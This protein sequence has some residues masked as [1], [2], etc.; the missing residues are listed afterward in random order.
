MTYSQLRSTYKDDLISRY[1]DLGF[2]EM[3][4]SSHGSDGGAIEEVPSVRE[5]VEGQA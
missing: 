4:Q 1:L 5:E 3:S 2:P